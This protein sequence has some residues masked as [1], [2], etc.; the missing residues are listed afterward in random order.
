MKIT[1]SNLDGLINCLRQHQD[2][3]AI[4]PNIYA[5]IREGFEVCQKRGIN[6]KKEKSIAIY[7]LPFFIS[8]PIIKNVFS[9][10]VLSLMFEGHVKHSPDEM[11]KMV[12]DILEKG[13]EY[14]MYLPML[15]R[16]QSSFN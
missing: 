3:F 1:A 9:K 12:H 16:F 8:I 2:R 10:E 5:S 13:K 15:E 7:Y 11:I 6:P 14:N 4:I